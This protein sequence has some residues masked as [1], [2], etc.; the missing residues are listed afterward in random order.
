MEWG[1][2]TML[3][4]LFDLPALVF[5]TGLSVDATVDHVEVGYAPKNDFDRSEFA[6]CIPPLAPAGEAET[7]NTHFR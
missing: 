6:K 2:Y 3:W 4:N 7:A 1:S 5:P